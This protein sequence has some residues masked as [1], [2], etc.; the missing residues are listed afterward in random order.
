MKEGAGF[1]HSLHFM[2][3]HTKLS[4]VSTCREKQWNSG[5]CKFFQRFFNAFIDV[6]V[7]QTNKLIDKLKCDFG[8]SGF[9]GI[10]YTGDL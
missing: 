3:A 6:D 10:R 2:P 9:W 7:K 1:P 4:T 8:R 5:R